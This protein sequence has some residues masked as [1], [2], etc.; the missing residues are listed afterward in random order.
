MTCLESGIDGIIATN[1]TIT[2]PEGLRG[3]EA[4]QDGGLSGQPLFELSTR[5]LGDLYRLTEGKI[6]LIG[7]GGV[8]NGEQAYAKIRAGASAGAA[9]FGHGLSRPRPG[10]SHQPRTGVAASPRWLLEDLRGGRFGPPLSSEK[11]LS[12]RP[13]AAA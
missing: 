11:P 6:P 12:P 8:S 5:I 1:T 7:V 2:R 13:P 4:G 3:T 10:Q 9:L